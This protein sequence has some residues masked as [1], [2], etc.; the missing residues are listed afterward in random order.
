MRLVDGCGVFLSG[1]CALHCAVTPLLVGVL[2]AIAGEGT[3]TNLRRVL[4]VLGLGGV[5]FGALFHRDRRAFVPL[6][7]AL[8][9]AALLEVG[10]I[11][12][13]WEVFV[14]LALSG[15][16]IT[17]HALNTRACN[18]HCHGCSPAR[19]WTAR[20]EEL[21]ASRMS[22]GVLA[23]AAAILLHAVVLA[24]ALR[25]SPSVVVRPE[26]VASAE[27]EVDWLAATPVIDAEPEAVTPAPERLDFAR[28]VA[29]V[30]APVSGRDASHVA[31]PAASRLADS[32]ADSVS[33][34][35]PSPHAENPKTFDDLLVAHAPEQGASEQDTPVSFDRVLTAPSGSAL[36]AG[37]SQGGIA[38]HPSGRGTSAA[39][40]PSSE[41][42]T[43]KASELSRAPTQPAGLGARIEAH[44]PPAARLQGVSGLGRARLLVSPQGTVVRG[45][46][47]SETPSGSGFADA[48]V[49]ALSGSGGWG[50]PLDARG[51][52]VSTWI[53]FSCEFTV[54]H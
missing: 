41:G 53:R 24:V 48:C 20:V 26:P 51:R 19:F 29:P 13:A 23:M 43:V 16:L 28:D 4:I 21:G 1:L 38:G 33:A 30:S 17:A 27:I 40:A 10:A 14:S 22:S 45:E 7:G 15:L 8:M 47:L 35:A 32:L 11:V 42:S 2:P 3:E 5:A 37:G 52:P 12:P 9:L 34:A 46:P 50:L 39:A 44:Y 18:A 25:A 36:G 54:R 31:P 6:A 49:A